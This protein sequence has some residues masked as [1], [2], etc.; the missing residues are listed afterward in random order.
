MSLGSLFPASF[1]NLLNKLHVG[2]T[3]SLTLGPRRLGDPSTGPLAFLFVHPEAPGTNHWVQL[4]E[5]IGG[6]NGGGCFAPEA[7]ALGGPGEALLG[8]PDVKLARHH[9]IG[10]TNAPC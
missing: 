1:S 5:L 10:M 9:A 3:S 8:P 7:S 4:I 2:L 6:V